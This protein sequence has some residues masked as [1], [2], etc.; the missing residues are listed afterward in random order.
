MNKMEPRDKYGAKVLAD[1]DSQLVR[2]NI[3]QTSGAV[4]F[5]RNYEGTLRRASQGAEIRSR[6]G[7]FDNE[8]G[9]NPQ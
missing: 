8:T 6:T 5:L 9:D 2:D 1:G 3:P 7:R 4:V